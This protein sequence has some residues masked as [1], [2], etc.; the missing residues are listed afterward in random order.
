MAQHA[1]CFR[2][3]VLIADTGCSCCVPIN[4]S[5]R[6]IRQP[7]SSSRALVHRR[8]LLSHAQQRIK[9]RRRTIE[10]GMDV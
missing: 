3:G 8:G 7:G 4:A 6:P 5:I 2:L 10:M 1:A 9:P